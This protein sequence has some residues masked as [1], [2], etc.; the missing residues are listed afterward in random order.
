MLTQLG[1]RLVALCLGLIWFVLV[2][3]FWF[4]FF[5]DLLY[6]FV[7]NPVA[8]LLLFT[9][10]AGIG[11]VIIMNPQQEASQSSGIPIMEPLSP[12]PQGK[13]ERKEELSLSE[14]N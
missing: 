13:Y 4:P 10:V 1:D 14:L 3:N 5:K 12:P 7:G 11:I 6:I 9:S 2:R 8:L